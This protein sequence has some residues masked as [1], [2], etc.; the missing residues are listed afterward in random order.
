[1]QENHH[2][3]M[4]YIVMGVS[5]CGKTTIGKLLASKKQIPFFDADDFHPA[6]NIKKMRAGIPLD[7][8][9]REP[10]LQILSIEI[11][12]WNMIGGA[13]LACSALKQ[14]YRVILQSNTSDVIFIWLDGSY[15]LIKSRMQNREGH[16][17]PPGLLQSQFDALE[18]PA[19]ALKVDIDQSP[20]SILSDIHKYI[21]EFNNSF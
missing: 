1:M 3:S 20:K 19:E 10:W 5:G 9:D 13:V 21:E 4:V 12:E 14:N 16:Y 8:S 7:D 6:D 11:E 18:P 17:M 15:N 2:I